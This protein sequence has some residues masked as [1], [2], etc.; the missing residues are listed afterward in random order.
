M[1]EILKKII[2]AILLLIGI[3]LGIVK[4]TFKIIKIIFL[5]PFALWTKY[6]T[7]KRKQMP[8]N[9]DDSQNTPL[10]YDYRGYAQNIENGIPYF[11]VKNQ[12]KWRLATKIE[13]LHEETEVINFDNLNLTSFPDEIFKCKKI[14]ILWLSGNEINEIPP[15]IGKYSM[16]QWLNL[17]SNKIKTLPAEIGGL[18]SLIQL[19]LENNPIPELPKE[20]SQFKEL[21]ILNLSNT[22]FKNKWEGIKNIQ[23]LKQLKLNNAKLKKI[24]PQIGQL[25]NLMYLELYNNE[26][27]EL[28]REIGQLKKIKRLYLGSNQLNSIPSEIGQLKEL[29]TLSISSNQLNSIPSE[30]GQLKKL[31]SILLG[32]NNLSYLPKEIGHLTA[33]SELD[34]SKNQLETLPIEIGQLESLT[35]LNLN[36]NKIKTIPE[37]LK[38]LSK[39]EILIFSNNE[40]EELTFLTNDLPKLSFIDFSFNRI[41]KISSQFCYDN[42]LKELNLVE[43]QLETLPPEIGQLVNLECLILEK[44][45]LTHLPPEMGQLVKLNSLNLRNNELTSLPVEFDNLSKLSGFVLRDNK[46][47]NITFEIGK[48]K[49]DSL[50]RAKDKLKL[51]ALVK[52]R[53]ENLSKWKPAEI[54]W[55]IK[56]DTEKEIEEN[57]ATK[58]AEIAAINWS[59]ALNFAEKYLSDDKKQVAKLSTYLK[60][61]LIKDLVSFEAIYGYKGNENLILCILLYKMFLGTDLDIG[62][63]HPFLYCRM[64]LVTVEDLTI[65]NIESLLQTSPDLMKILSSHH[66]IGNDGMGGRFFYNFVSHPKSSLFYWDHDFNDFSVIYY[67]SWQSILESKQISWMLELTKIISKSVSNFISEFPQEMREDY[68][69]RRL[70]DY[71]YAFHEVDIAQSIFNQKGY[72]YRGVEFENEEIAQLLQNKES[73]Y[74]EHSYVRAAINPIIAYNYHVYF[75]SNNLH[76]LQELL[77]VSKDIKGGFYQLIRQ[78]FVELLAGKPNYGHLTNEMIE[79]IYKEGQAQH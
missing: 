59:E 40:I 63:N 72:I 78:T 53:K 31:G 18:V 75:L 27:M 79:K 3:I 67:S 29:E 70:I 52:F 15:A 17:G 2:T 36:S 73:E 14:L 54:S 71:L 74:Y 64:E 8:L 58:S 57:L 42:K 21:E 10:K 62:N 5:L 1:Y 25:T 34:L 6:K 45:K 12:G 65:N 50:K 39:L 30:I 26:L 69:Q 28:P 11:H 16:L 23:S 22:P 19:N 13:E 77:A 44:N 61:Q 60:E 9:Q 7:S 56:K 47:A 24:S 76:L 43:N 51:S 66:I 48:L 20:V 68:S 46:E 4:N 32:N 41:K 33:L 35:N 37:G 49:A 38:S 55:N